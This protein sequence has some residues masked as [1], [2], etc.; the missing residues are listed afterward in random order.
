MNPAAQRLVDGK[1]QHLLP[2]LYHFYADPPVLVRGQMQYLFDAGGRRY[3]D[4]YAGV[5]VMNAGHCNPAILGPALAQAGQL[6]HTTSI[7]LT[8]PMIALAAELAAFLGPGFEKCFFVNSGSEA[9]EGALLLARLFTGRHGFIALRGG[10]HGRTHLTMSLTGLD[11][12]RT[13]PHPSPAARLAPRPHCA[14]CE[15]G[16]EFGSCGYA[17]VEAVAAMLEADGNV[18][19]LIAEPI[20]GNGGIVAPPPEYFSRLRAV[21]AARGVLLILDEVQTGFSRTGADMRFHALGA[22]PD[23]V[24]VAKALGNGFPIGAFCAGERIAACYTRPGAST[25]GGNPVASTAALA[26]LKYHRERGLAERATRLGAELRVRLNAL[27][28]DHPEECREL[29]GAGLMLGLELSRGGEPLARET[30]AILEDLKDAGYL[31][32]KTGIGRNVLT[33]MPPLVIEEPDIEGLCD[34]LGRVLAARLGSR[35]G[36]GA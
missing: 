33:F 22:K 24:T 36:G 20:Q 29:R 15:L 19:A 35:A 10:L 5:T 12:W 25:T 7:Y 28:A 4:F 9:N 17:C 6:Q 27:A 21:L 1:R 8:E 18:A 2:C 3:T 13:D 23:I 34:S 30:E 32:G 14:A 26:V 11:L 16:R 31:A